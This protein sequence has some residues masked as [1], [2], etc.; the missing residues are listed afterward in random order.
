MNNIE[1][2]NIESSQRR[3]ENRKQTKTNV[4]T[5]NFSFRR[6]VNDKKRYSR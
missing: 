3:N 4:I 5:E 1:S 2:Y 6:R